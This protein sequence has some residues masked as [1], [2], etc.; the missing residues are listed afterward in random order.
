MKLKNLYN[1]FFKITCNVPLR[2]RNYSETVANGIK[3]QIFQNIQS[4]APTEFFNFNVFDQFYEKEINDVQIYNA[5]FPI[6]LRPKSNESF[7]MQL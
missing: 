7:Q 5:H 3:M 2:R 1:K 4:N 6:E